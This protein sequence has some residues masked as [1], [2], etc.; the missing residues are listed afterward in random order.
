[1]VSPAYAAGLRDGDVILMLDSTHISRFSGIRAFM[2]GKT[3]SDIS[4]RALRGR[5]TLDFQVKT[6]S[7]PF[8]GVSSPVEQIFKVDTIHYGFFES[9]GPGTTDAFGLLSANVQGFRNLARPGVEVSKSIMGPIQIA[10]TYLETFKVGGVEAFIRLTGML[11]MVLAFIN[12]LPIPALDGGHVVFLLIEA[13]TRKEP[14][15]KV[16]LIAQQIGMVIVLML[17]IYFLFNDVFQATN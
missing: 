8:L 2:K 13:I 15:V 10:M 11:S 16:R 14:S 7:I 1:M 12:I 6:D 5:D 9:F 3:F 17:M 4:V